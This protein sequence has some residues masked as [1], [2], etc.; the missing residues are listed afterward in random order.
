MGVAED[1][2]VIVERSRK[3]GQHFKGVIDDHVVSEDGDIE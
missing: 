2:G 3:D 1:Y